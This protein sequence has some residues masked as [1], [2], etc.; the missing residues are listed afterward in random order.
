MLFA[1]PERD[2]GALSN[3][4]YSYPMRETVLDRG[5]S[6]W[7]NGASAVPYGRAR[8]GSVRGDKGHRRRRADRAP[9][10]GRT[11]GGSLGGENAPAARL[12]SHVVEKVKP[13]TGRLLLFW[14][15]VFFRG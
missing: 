12:Q 7:S 6:G 9:G 3:P 13:N 5:L 11:G 15:H 2:P 10:R 14:L 4:D 8:R 1:A